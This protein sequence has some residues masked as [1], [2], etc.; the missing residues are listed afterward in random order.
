MFCPVIELIALDFERSIGLCFCQGS[1]S[2]KVSAC[3]TLDLHG[4]SCTKEESSSMA[5]IQSVQA[6]AILSPEPTRAAP[7]HE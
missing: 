2:S 1:V 6:G 7:L 3:Y 5:N 4:V